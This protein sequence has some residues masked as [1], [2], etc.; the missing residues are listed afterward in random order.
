MKATTVKTNKLLHAIIA[1]T[2]A[3]TALTGTSHISH[4]SQ[5]HINFNFSLF[6][7]ANAATTNN[8]VSIQ[9]TAFVE[10]TTKDSTGKD[11]KTEALATNVVPGETVTFK[12]VISNKG[13]TPAKDIVVTNPLPDHMTF[14]SAY[15]TDTNNT[16]ITYSLDGKEF[17]DLTKLSVKDKTTG[18]A[19]SA[20]PEEVKF[21]RWAVK[22]QLSGNS[23]LEV[24]YK[25]T[26]Q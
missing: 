16:N 3:F 22:T 1:S 12:N 25:A 6:Q 17:G 15:S 26:L 2:L 7:S 10:Q 9:S 24:G 19:R 11:V 14:V 18:N 21:V 23:N 13:A 20:L 5:S 8:N 4:S